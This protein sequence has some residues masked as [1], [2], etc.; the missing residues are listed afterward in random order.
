MGER[1]LSPGEGLVAVQMHD[2]RIFEICVPL[3]WWYA[4]SPDQHLGFLT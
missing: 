3:D 4:L 1:E 2:D